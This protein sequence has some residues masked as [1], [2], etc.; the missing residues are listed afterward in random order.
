MWRLVAAAGGCCAIGCAAPRAEFA[1]HVATSQP[2]TI[3]ATQLTAGVAAAVRTEIQAAV[4][5]TGV[6][7]DVTGYSSQFGVGAT[8][9]VAAA[10]VLTLVLSH[11][12]EMAR[13]AR[14]GG[15]E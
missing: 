3:D 13:I 9:C 15:G 10:L 1:P 11:R 8:L 7:R 5:T 2:V 6:G 12:R 14:N 4:T